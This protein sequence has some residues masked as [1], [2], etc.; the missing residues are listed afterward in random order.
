MVAG[1]NSWNDLEL[2]GKIKLFYFRKYF[3]YK[4]GAPSDD[5]LRRFFRV[6]DPEIFEKF[7]VDW[8]RAFQIDLSD[9]VVAVDGKTSRRSFDGENKPMHLVSAFVS[10][11]GITL[12]H[13]F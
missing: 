4:Q 2:F 9:R 6:L 7:F 10:E 8:V 12:V 5:R 11:L 3:P 1:C 13:S